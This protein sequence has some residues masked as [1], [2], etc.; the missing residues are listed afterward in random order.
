[1]VGGEKGSG[2]NLVPTSHLFVCQIKETVLILIFFAP[3]K[4]LSGSKTGV[5]HL[6]HWRV[7]EKFFFT[8]GLDR[9]QLVPCTPLYQMDSSGSCLKKWSPG[10]T[11]KSKGLIM[12]SYLSYKW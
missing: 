3:K 4:C 8:R 12:L 11:V 9:L 6:F 10:D 5:G 1:M 7:K 2:M